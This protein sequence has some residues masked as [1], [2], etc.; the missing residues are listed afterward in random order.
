MTEFDL[1]YRKI[2]K[3]CQ[4]IGRAI[5]VIYV[6]FAVIFLVGTFANG[7]EIGKTLCR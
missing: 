5:V 3:D 2:E 7:V 4:S 1:I 6:E